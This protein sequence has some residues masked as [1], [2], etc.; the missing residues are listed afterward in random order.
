[1][2]K[3]TR[4]RRPASA[5]FWGVYKITSEGLEL[6]QGIGRTREDAVKAAARELGCLPHGENLLSEKGLRQRR[7]APGR[8]AETSGYLSL[9]IG[10]LQRPQPTI[11]DSRRLGFGLPHGR[12]RNWP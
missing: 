4:T 5:A 10:F 11:G 12:K 3:A 9:P 2:A 8:K 6:V 1:M 7:A